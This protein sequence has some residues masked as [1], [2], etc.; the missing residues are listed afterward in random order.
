MK[1][2]PDTAIGAYRDLEA[3]LS[4]RQVVVRRLLREYRDRYDCWPTALELLRYAVATHAPGAQWDVNAIR[5][6][7]FELHEQGYAAHGVKRPC[8]LSGKRVYTWVAIEPVPPCYA[9][10]SQARQVE[11]F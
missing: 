1:R 5:P 8:T 4:D 7:L 3:T 11:L 2:Q 9:D 10:L 6:R